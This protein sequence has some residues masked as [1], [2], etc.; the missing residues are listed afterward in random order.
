MPDEQQRAGRG[1]NLT[2]QG[3]Q[4]RG[5]GIV[6]PGVEGD[7]RRGRQAGLC[8]LPGLPGPAGGGTQHLAGHEAGVAE[9]ASHHG[10]GPDAAARQRPFVVSPPA[11]ASAASVMGLFSW[12]NIWIYLLA[13]LA[14]RAVAALAFRYLN[15]CN[16]F[17]YLNPCNLFRY[18]NPCDLEPA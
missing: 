1:R 13:D 11:V 17:R 15:P 9:P 8:E 12:S 5:R 14:G 7:R 16:L 3:Q 2:D 6:D 18:L 4:I 10:R